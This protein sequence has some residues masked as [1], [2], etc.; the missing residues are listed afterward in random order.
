MW[1]EFQSILTWLEGF[2]PSN[3]FSSLSKIDSQSK[4]S[5]LGAPGSYMTGRSCG[6][7]ESA[8]RKPHPVLPY[9]SISHRTGQ[10]A[11]VALKTANAV[12]SLSCFEEDSTKLFLNVN[13]TSSTLIIFLHSSNHILSLWGC[14]CCCRRRCYSSQMCNQPSHLAVLHESSTAVT[15]ICNKIANITDIPPSLHSKIILWFHLICFCFFERPFMQTLNEKIK[16]KS[17][18]VRSESHYVISLSSRV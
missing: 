14:F 11:Q 13:S 7:A 17:R 1:V 4:T 15:W 3:P 2:S 9:K 5:G 12:I 8:L 18:L 10:I 6:N 16:I